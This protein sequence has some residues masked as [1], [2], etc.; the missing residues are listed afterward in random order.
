MT[1]III[2]NWNGSQM[3]QR[4]LPS[5]VANSG[6]AEVVVADNASTDDSLQMLSEKFPTVRIVT[7][8]RNWGFADG[9]K[10]ACEK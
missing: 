10:K 1:T 5:V 8:D 3:M 2:L 7:L 6:D 9:Y 4:Y